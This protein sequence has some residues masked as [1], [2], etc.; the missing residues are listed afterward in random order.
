M[1]AETLN[2]G[3]KSGILSGNIGFPASEVSQ[4]ATDKDTLVMELSSFQLMGTDTS[5]HTW[6]LLQT[7]CQHILTTMVAL[8]N[9]LLQN[10]IFKRI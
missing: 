5:T 2:N 4:T 9:M 6:L 7:L 1:I 8:K 3:G 10:G